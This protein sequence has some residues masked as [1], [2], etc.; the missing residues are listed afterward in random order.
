MPIE[1][2]LIHGT[3]IIFYKSQKELINYY[4]EHKDEHIRIG[5][6]GRDFCLEHLK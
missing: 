5:T 3:H 4:I 2:R 1:N 6:N